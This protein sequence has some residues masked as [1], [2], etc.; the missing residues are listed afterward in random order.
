MAKKT[1]LKDYWRNIFWRNNAIFLAGSLFVAFLN[2]L[3]YPILGRLMEV[4]SFGEVQVL[5]SIFNLVGMLLTAFQIVTVN[6]SANNKKGSA[7]IIRQFE[8]MALMFMLGLL[9]VIVFLSPKLQKFFNF[10]SYVPFMVLGVALVI[11][12]LITFRRA[13]VQGRSD[14]TAVSIS[15]G[16]GALGK[17]LFSALLVVA[18]LKTFGA[19]AGI[20]LSQVIAL[21]YTARVAKRLGFAAATTERF[22]MPN[23]K[24]L[25]PELRYLFSVMTVFFIIT[26]LYLGDVLVVKRYFD[27]ELAGQFAG[28]S[29]ISK[30]IFF[31]TASFAGVLLASVGQSHPRD[32]NRKISKNSLLL[33]TA[34]GGSA[35]IVFS[36]FPTEIIRLM[37]GQRYAELAHLLPSLSL[38]V[39]FAS[40][41]NLYFYYFLALRQYAVVPIAAIGGIITFSLTIL[42]HGTL[43]EVIQNFLIGNL[44]VLCLMIS[45]G[46]INRLRVQPEQA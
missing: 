33:V 34:I 23:I 6:I 17:L 8:R 32:Y 10:S 45:L 29:A 42:R 3:Y 28:V 27:P 37:I 46:L 1:I 38:M 11:T 26:L 19:I 21:A 4:S 12:V 39:F 16:I 24:L 15:G 9:V 36:L 25:K 14:F 30:I 5:L 41:A 44:S 13:Y 40:V 35:L 2:Y 7:E 31:A 18:G 20:L 22:Q 43:E